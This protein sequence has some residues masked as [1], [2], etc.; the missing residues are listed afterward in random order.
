LFLLLSFFL[1][2]V[3]F[4]ICFC[5]IVFI[6]QVGAIWTFPSF[7]SLPMGN[8]L[9]G[10]PLLRISVLWLMFFEELNGFHL[11]RRNY[12]NFRPLLSSTV[13]NYFDRFPFF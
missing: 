11:L 8:Y 9:V 1:T 13:G 5:L 6:C 3:L 7:V 2:L 4:G 10:F 12:L